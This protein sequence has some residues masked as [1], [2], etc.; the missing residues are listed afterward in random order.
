LVELG[1]TKGQAVL[2]IYL[3]TITCGLGALLLRRVDTYGAGI[4]LLIV[5]CILSLIAILEATS[6]RRARSSG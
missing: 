5:F 3:T 1:L 6:R 4:I 2:T